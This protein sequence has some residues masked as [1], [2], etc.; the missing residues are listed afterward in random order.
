[1]G[2]EGV[3]G[4]LGL[5]VGVMVRDGVIGRRVGVRF[6][7][8]RK[9]KHFFKHRNQPAGQPNFKHYFKH[10]A[11]AGAAR[12]RSGRLSATLYTVNFKF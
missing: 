12:G 1:M 3:L 5:G 6:P 8:G 9:F 4:V 10:G 7:A 11:A 2:G